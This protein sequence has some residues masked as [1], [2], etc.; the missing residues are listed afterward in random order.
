MISNGDQYENLFI[1][2]IYTQTERMNMEEAFMQTDP[3]HMNQGC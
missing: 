3:T 1:D 2:E